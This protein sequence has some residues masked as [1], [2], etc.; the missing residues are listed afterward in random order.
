M[1]YKYRVSIAH[2][3]WTVK[4]KV[5]RAKLAPLSLKLPLLF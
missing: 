1:I 4:E 2:D 5:A 3:E